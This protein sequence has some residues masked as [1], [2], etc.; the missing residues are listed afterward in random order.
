MYIIMTVIVIVQPQNVLSAHQKIC[1]QYLA[2]EK[3]K[4]SAKVFEADENEYPIA[5]F[6]NLQL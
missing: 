2:L 4:Y 5:S 6:L 3:F 1:A